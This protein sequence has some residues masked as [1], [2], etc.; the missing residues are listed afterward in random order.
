M[1]KPAREK[2]LCSSSTRSSSSSFSAHTNLIAKTN[3][4]KHTC[5]TQRHNS[6]N[7]PTIS[8]NIKRTSRVSSFLI[9]IHKYGTHVALVSLKPMRML[10]RAYTPNLS[11]SA[12]THTHAHAAPIYVECAAR[13]TTTTTTA[14]TNIS[15]TMCFCLRAS[16]SLV[17]AA[18]CCSSGCVNIAA[19]ICC[20][21]CVCWL[22]RRVATSLA[23]SLGFA[24]RGDE[25]I[26]HRTKQI[27]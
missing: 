7:V 18:C 26:T 25:R 16:A 12:H 14:T 15:V 4:H 11:L 3:P 23:L 17:S 1:T 6:K 22:T 8:L 20:L 21:N 2:D 9:N 19:C 10:S 5:C 13:T 27:R 24:R